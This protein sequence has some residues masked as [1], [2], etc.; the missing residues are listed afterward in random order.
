MVDW[1]RGHGQGLYMQNQT[2]QKTI[3]NVISFNSFTDG[4]KAY[5]ESGFAQNFLFEHIISFN[6]GAPAGFPGNPGAGG[7]PIAANHRYS[8]I[9]AGTGNSNNP[10][11]NILIHDSHLYDPPDTNPENGNLGLGYQG[12]GATGLEITNNRIMGGIHAI[13]LNHFLGLTVTGNKIY[14]QNSGAW[15]GVGGSGLVDAQIEAG[16]KA[17][18]N[19][20]TYYDQLPRYSNIS[21]P[22]MMTVGG[23][24]QSTCEGGAALRFSYTGCTPNGGWQQ[25]TAL[26]SSS[27]Y[28]YAAPTGTD[29]SVTPNE[30]ETGRAH[31]AIYNWALNPTVAVNVS[32]VLNSGDRFAVYAAEDYLG[33]PVLTGTYTGTPISIPMTGTTVSAPI[34]LGWTPATVRPRFGAFVIRKQ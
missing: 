22:F 25:I 20:N 19:N 4:M 10:I 11:N 17:T 12:V 29:V 21:Y 34:G 6:N 28:A 24:S 2:G 18:W 9:Y 31:I 7:A 30:Y 26:D 27:T 16:A 8:N 33:T 15:P 13:E 14:A 1:Q 32:S 23:T 3:R 5:A